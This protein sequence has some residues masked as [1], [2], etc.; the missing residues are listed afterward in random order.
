[1]APLLMALPESFGGLKALHILN[2]AH[3]QLTTLPGSFGNLQAL[4]TLH[5]WNNR[6]PP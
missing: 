3:N 2:L 1:M 4:Q 5:L 6:L